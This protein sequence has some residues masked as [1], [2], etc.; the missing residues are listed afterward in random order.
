MAQNTDHYKK[1]ISTTLVGVISDATSPMYREKESNYIV[2]LKIIDETMNEEK[3][4]GVMSKDCA[5]YLISK[6]KAEIDLVNEL[7]A[8]VLLDKFSFSLW[9]DIKLEAK[10]QGITEGLFVVESD[11][12]RP[13][14]FKVKKS[15]CMNPDLMIRT[16]EL[17]ER[18]R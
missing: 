3:L 8:I 14:Q 15:L 7:G 16:P 18:V 13:D 9:N 5:V 12:D 6:N 4:F 10:Y 11:Q 17:A 2:M 1:P